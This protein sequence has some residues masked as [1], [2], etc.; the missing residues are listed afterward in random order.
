MLEAL[1]EVDNIALEL[2][3]RSARFIGDH[4]QIRAFQSMRC[5][6]GHHFQQALNFATAGIFKNISLFKV[7]L[8]N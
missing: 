2:Q 8:T 3:K 1:T 6:P 7:E 4:S 5:N